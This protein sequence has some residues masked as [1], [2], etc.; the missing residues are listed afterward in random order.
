[1]HMWSGLREER[2][3]E[4]FHA[5][6]LQAIIITGL[7]DIHESHHICEAQRAGVIELGKG[8][9]YCIDCRN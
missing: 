9:G 6:I 1:M 4:F 7:N 5:V 2:F 3:R 8:F